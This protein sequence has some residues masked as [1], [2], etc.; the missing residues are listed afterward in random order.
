MSQGGSMNLKRREGYNVVLY[1]LNG[2]IV[3]TCKE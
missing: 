1:V 3:F 2:L